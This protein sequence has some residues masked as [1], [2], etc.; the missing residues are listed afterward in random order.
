M[1][2]GTDFLLS[3][4]QQHFWITQGREA[5]KKVKREC[6]QCRRYQARPLNQLMGDLPESRLCDGEPPFT[7][8]AIDY[9]GPIE[10]EYGRDRMKKMWGAIFTCMTTRAIYLDLALSLSSDDF[11]LILRRFIGLY[12]KPKRIHSDNGTNFVG[13][14]KILREAVL[15]LHGAD[16]P[17]QF[18]KKQLIDWCFQPARTPHFGGTHE[19]LVRTTKRALYAALDQERS[20]QRRPTE[21]MLRTLLYEVAGLLN[22]RPLT[23]ASSDP[24]DPRPLT[25]NDFLNRPPAADLPVGEFQ[26]AL[27]REHFRYVQRMVDQFWNLWRGTYLQSLVGRQKWRSRQRNLAVGDFVMEIDPNLRRGQ[28]ST[29]HVTQVFPG[30]D[31]LVRAVD[32]QLRNGIFRRGIRHLCLLEP[33]SPVGAQ[34]D[35]SG[36]GEDGSA[37]KEIVPDS[38]V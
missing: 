5:V 3:Q 7:R 17:N 10:V 34:E 6:Q 36:S 11:L 1:H 23:Y 38:K 37:K 18:M 22:S 24:E 15:D 4:I 12:G 13:A 29:G 19:S 35:Q 9:F 28:W 33:S 27:P 21:D 14:E 26:D 32:V 25:P 31:G 8:T 2:V 20:G 16:T 30:A